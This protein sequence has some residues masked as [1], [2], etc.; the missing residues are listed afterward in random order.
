MPSITACGG[1]QQAYDKFCTALEDADKTD[2]IVLLVDSEDPVTQGNS[3]WVHLHSRDGWTKPSGATDDCAHLMV[4]CMETW[5]LADKDEDESELAK[6]FG[7]GFNK[8]LLPKNSRI[9]EI[10]KPDVENGLKSATRQST[11]K[12]EYD[13]GRDSF[14]I[15]ALIDPNK[16]VAASP[17]AK[18]LI[19]TL[20]AKAGV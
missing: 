9:E 11:P 4:V 14:A 19:D 10:S 7:Q 1:R 20:K 15:L 16:V 12:G 2:F 8:N 18:D 3:P 13:K 5:F 17:H 6:Y